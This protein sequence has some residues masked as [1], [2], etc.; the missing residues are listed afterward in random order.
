MEEEVL[1]VRLWWMLLYK[2][3]TIVHCW[4]WHKGYLNRATFVLEWHLNHKWGTGI[5]V[6]L[7]V[8]YCITSQMVMI[9]DTIVSTCPKWPRKYFCSYSLF[10]HFLRWDYWMDCLLIGLYLEFVKIKLSYI[11]NYLTSNSWVE[12]CSR[13]R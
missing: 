9:C 1:I 4:A 12:L 11:E 7:H 13:C 10:R 6:R 8:K 2:C 5:D 3:M